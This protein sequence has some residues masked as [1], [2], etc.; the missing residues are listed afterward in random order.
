[1]KR[2][3]APH[4]PNITMSD[5]LLPPSTAKS[6]EELIDRVEAELVYMMELVESGEIRGRDARKVARLLTLFRSN[7]GRAGACKEQAG[8]GKSDGAGISK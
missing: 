7:R 4:G 6:R 8:T 1:M 5:V 3:E 2:T